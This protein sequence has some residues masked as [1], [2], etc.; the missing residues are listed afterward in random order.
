MNWSKIFS[1]A[2]ANGMEYFIVEQEAYPNGTAL[3]AAKV[4]A[5]FMKG[6]KI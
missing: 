5:E 3:E 6:L 2:R 4:N 1:T